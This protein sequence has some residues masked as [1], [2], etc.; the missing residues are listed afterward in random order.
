MK[1]NIETAQD[2]PVLSA[3]GFQR[4]LAAAFILQ[5]Q[6]D[7]HLLMPRHGGYHRTVAV[8]AVVQKRTPS[9]R[10]EEPQ[11]Q[12]AYP[13]GVLVSSVNGSGDQSSISASQELV[14]ILPSIAHER[15]RARRAALGLATLGE[16]FVTKLSGFHVAGLI[17]LIDARK[18]VRWRTVEALAIATVFGMLMGASMHRVSRARDRLSLPTEVAEPQTADR[19][20]T[21]AAEILALSG[22]P[23]VRLTSHQS[24]PGHEADM[25]AKDVVIRY[26]NRASDLRQPPVKKL[27]ILPMQ[28][29]LL[30]RD[31][32]NLKPGVQ[33]TFGRG[34]QAEMLAA[35]TVVRYGT[36]ST[37][38]RVGDRK[39]GALISQSYK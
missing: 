38:S 29:Q 1:Q 19:T 7:P 39:Q 3:D 10:I 5:T 12:L 16:D 30:P 24:T 35:D 37:S 36:G 32:A 11:L 22:P 27:T 8:E 2:K 28:A 21:A 13:N 34:R 4:L 9:L 33:F 20:A 17:S 14:E 31:N 15:T 25:V 6:N 18:V 23:I 26:Q